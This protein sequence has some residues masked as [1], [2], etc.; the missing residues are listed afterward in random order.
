MPD[1]TGELATRIRLVRR[2]MS[3]LL[4]H[5]TR[6]SANDSA[7]VVLRNI[8][9]DRS[10]RGTGSWT[11]G[12][13]CVCFTEAPIPEFAAIFSLVEIASSKDL[14]PRYEP[15]GIAVPKDW[16]FDRGGRPV[17]Y[18]KKSSFG[19]YSEEQ[20]YRL[21]H[22]DPRA[23]IDFTWEREWRIR[24]AKLPLDPPTTLIVVPTAEEAF[25]LMEASVEPP[26]GEGTSASYDV[27]ERFRIP[28]WM[29]VSLDLFGVKLDPTNPPRRG[30]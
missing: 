24:T 23:G 26:S 18:E 8:L 29:A 6:G 28:K 11:Q 15:Y 16:L 2:D 12:E 9:R 20:R 30:T 22:F 5:F 17:I 10:L 13:A 25:S 7:L 27:A 3:S 21:A 4:F 14:R 19:T 1:L